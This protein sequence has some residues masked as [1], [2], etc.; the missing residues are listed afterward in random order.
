MNAS[1]K[2]LESVLET[3]TA[4]MEGRRMLKHSMDV[5]ASHGHQLDETLL[6]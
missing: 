5:S 4:Y 1:F 3:L 2:V 6:V